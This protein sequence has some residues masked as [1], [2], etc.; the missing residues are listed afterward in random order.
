MVVAFSVDLETS[1]SVIIVEADDV[2]WVAKDDFVVWVDERVEV[3]TFEEF[4]AVAAVCRI[5]NISER[6]KMVCRS[7]NDYKQRRIYT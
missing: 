5:G 7:T 6:S 2:V 4:I 3:A 1:C